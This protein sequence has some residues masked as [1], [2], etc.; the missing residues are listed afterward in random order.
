MIRRIQLV[1]GIGNFDSVD[2]GKQ[3]D[4]R[5]LVLVYAENGRG[6]T[7]LTA[8]LRSLASG[9][10]TPIQARRSL[11]SDQPP[12]VVLACDGEPPTA[13]FQG[14]QWN[15]K[16]PHLTVFD[17]VFVHD[18][19]HSGLLLESRH[20]KNLLGVILGSQGVK[21][22]RCLKQIVDRAERHSSELRVKSTAIP[23]SVRFGFTVDE[24]CELPLIED[25][26]SQIRETERALAAASDQD[27]VSRAPLF[28][29]FAL[30]AFDTEAIDA[31]LGRSLGDLD[32]TA[33]AR[34]RSHFESLGP[35]AE[36]WVASGMQHLSPSGDEGSC[37]FCAQDLSASNI[38]G[39]YRA[40]FSEAYSEL[41]RSID[42]SL[43]AVQ[44]THGGD[45]AA[46]FERAVSLAI[47]RRAFWS[48]F[49]EVPKI[50]VDSYLIVQNWK[51]L[52]ESVLEQLRAKRAS[53]LERVDLP[54][55][56]QAAISLQKSHGEK[57]QELGKAIAASN[58]HAQKVKEKAAGASPE[59][60]DFKLKRLQAIRS[61]HLEVN[62]KLCD[63]Y[64]AE[65]GAKTRTDEKRVIARQN[66]SEYR[67][68]IFPELE[69]SI[70]YYLD[71]F[72]A[73]FRLARVEPVDTRG[74][75]SCTYSI[76]IH[77]RQVDVART[78]TDGQP[79]F[80]TTLSSGDR[81]TLALAFFFA[82][83]DH[84]PNLNQKVVVIDD[85]KSS[86][87][88]HRSLTTVHLARQFANRVEQM[89]ILSH[90]K[91]F[92]CN[93]G[94]R[95]R[96]S[97]PT[98]VEI[99]RDG[100]GSTLREW[101]VHEESVTEHDRRH[102]ILRDFVD[103]GTEDKGEIARCLR[104]HL[105]GFLRV[106]RPGEFPPETRMGNFLQI[107][108]D[109]LGQADEVLDREGTR[110]LSHILEYAN[111]FH[112]DA[113]PAWRDQVINDTELLGFV[114][115]VLVFARPHRT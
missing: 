2:T 16:L 40:Y 17:D 23:E 109:R 75:A 112:H 49:C 33:D 80:S 7:T 43:E 38:I 106:A 78:S 44:S 64:L 18:N 9:D 90:D 29:S 100:S 6:K 32:A 41:K 72:S 22:Q 37:P 70:N 15:R 68:G 51:S 47:Q 31:V 66:L 85:P 74:G 73:G 11:T 58:T 89:M 12:K 8:V 39:H 110:D 45:A 48:R 28:E 98:A 14:G 19:V 115:R 93:V 5:Q 104:P 25:I 60:I 71:E 63:D 77:D 52:R 55:S 91:G 108:C 54:E 30:P 111:K 57:I 13:V 82:A 81:N 113:N 27:A 101:P 36:Q 56:L 97:L 88:E 103:H 26:D 94:S 102:M 10:S 3:I 24:F 21:L 83:L 107:C 50:E 99:A 59:L 67:D 34:V 105:E 65:R 95:F 53:P 87:D 92:L 4:L 76:E 69:K 96:R 62:M 61:R 114:K 86:L 42:Q 46:G 35:G 20:R 1:Q 84:D 79:S